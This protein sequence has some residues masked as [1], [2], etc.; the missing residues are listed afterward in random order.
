MPKS[1]ELSN[2]F[3]EYLPRLDSQKH[4]VIVSKF[5]TLDITTTYALVHVNDKI[6]HQQNIL[7]AAHSKT[8]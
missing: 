2:H 3:L 8:K 4:L 6:I 5:G 7:L 1:E